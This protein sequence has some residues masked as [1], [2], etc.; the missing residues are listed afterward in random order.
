MKLTLGPPWRQHMGRR[1]LT[2]HGKS[3]DAW[4]LEGWI[5]G[6]RVDGIAVPFTTADSFHD[7]KAF[8][9]LGEMFGMWSFHLVFIGMVCKDF[10]PQKFGCSHIKDSNCSIITGHFKSFWQ[11]K[12]CENWSCLP[13]QQVWLIPKGIRWHNNVYTKAERY[14]YL[15]DQSA[16]SGH[17]Q[18]HELLE[19]LRSLAMQSLQTPGCPITFGGQVGWTF[20]AWSLH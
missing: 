15:T 20:D 3:Y 5:A 8:L 10:T 2:V 14:C 18:S 1:N 17:K 12:R 13:L 11:E 9:R 19:L 16:L 7:F 4:M 6:Y